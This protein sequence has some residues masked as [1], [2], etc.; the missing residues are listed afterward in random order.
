MQS[1][2]ERKGKKRTK[3]KWYVFGPLLGAVIT[4]LLLYAAAM[5]LER[6]IL[7]YGLAEEFVI[8]CL[9][10][11]STAG[12]AGAAKRRGTMTMA[13]GL[14]SGAIIAGILVVATLMIQGEGAL[15]SEC[16]K[17]V[18]AAVAGGAF[19]AALCLNRGGA[20]RKKRARRR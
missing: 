18:I 5:L 7:P 4:V 8:A 1:T 9:F 20:K 15:A 3:L 11:G 10:F 2:I 17:H 13:T 19:G 6:Q 16:F 12:G 14:M